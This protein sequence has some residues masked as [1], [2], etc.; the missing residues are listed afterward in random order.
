MGILLIWYELLIFIFIEE[1]T[2]KNTTKFTKSSLSNEGSDI[3]MRS[4]T[5]GPYHSL[6]RNII[7]YL[8]LAF[9]I[10]TMF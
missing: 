4:I 2:E 1:E 8:F 6:G 3:L 7:S 5:S 9:I 10:K